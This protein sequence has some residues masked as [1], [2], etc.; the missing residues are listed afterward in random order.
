MNKLHYRRASTGMS[1]CLSSL[2]PS[3]SFLSAICP[4]SLLFAA[5]THITSPRGRSGR[6]TGVATRQHSTGMG[7][8]VGPR[9]RD[10]PLT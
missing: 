9:L 10:P 7:R 4:P 1:A 5:G 2:F 3:L 8:K 6:T